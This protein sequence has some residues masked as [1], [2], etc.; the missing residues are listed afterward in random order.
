MGL[1]DE[2]EGEDRNC[3]CYEL[4]PVVSILDHPSGTTFGASNEALVVELLL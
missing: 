1:T 3:R 2:I 4:R